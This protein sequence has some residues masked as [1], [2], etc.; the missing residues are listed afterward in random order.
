MP[1]HPPPPPPRQRA[2]DAD[3]KAA[4]REV[5]LDAA[6]HLY[7]PAQPLP[8]VAEIAARAELAKGTM[9]LYFQ[10]KE[11]IY[12]GLHARHSRRFFEALVARLESPDVFGADD[13]LAI[14]DAHMIRAP[15]FLPLSNACMGAGAERIDEAS[16]EAFHHELAMWLMRAGAGLERRLPRLAPGDGARVLHHGYALM[17]G[18]YQLLGQPSQ[19]A[20]HRRM[21]ERGIASRAGAV[22]AGP[23][24]FRTESH[25]ALRGLWRQ[26]ESHGLVPAAP[27]FD[28]S[29]PS[30]PTRRP[31]KAANA[32]APTSRA[33]G[34]RPQ[35][36][37]NR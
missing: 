32:A 27:P 36:A 5:I 37:S 11:A 29:I 28:A 35:R 8:G 3:E 12:L 4:R 19:C 17:L 26:V 21:H 10:T 2:I 6:E 14:V 1:R 18:L 25:A 13:M 23:P 24:D 22:A 34:A 20:V 9:Y 7:D 16:H 15:A 30:R 33:H 31:V